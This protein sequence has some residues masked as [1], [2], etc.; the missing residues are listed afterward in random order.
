LKGSLYA[1]WIATWGARTASLALSACAGG[2]DVVPESHDVHVASA[3]PGATSPAGAAGYEYVAKRPMGVVAVAESRG[4]PIDV[5]HGVADRLADSLDIC[6]TRLASEGRLAPAAARVA[7]H[8]GADGTPEGLALT[9]TPGPGP[10]ANALLCF[11][12]PFKLL[13]FPASQ[14]GPEAR[15]LALEA[16]W[17][18]LAAGGAAR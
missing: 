9:L 4:L 6:A 11:V 15:G 7:A 12:S 5:V 8:I 18:T 17:G 10:T 1:A 14:V 2:R 3:G 16:S 13:R